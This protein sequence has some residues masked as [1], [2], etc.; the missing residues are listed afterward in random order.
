MTWALPAILC[1]VRAFVQVLED[2][3]AQKPVE[4]DQRFSPTS[5]AWLTSEIREKKQ[6]NFFVE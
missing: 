1:V 5:A 4:L 2:A 6:Q 3:T